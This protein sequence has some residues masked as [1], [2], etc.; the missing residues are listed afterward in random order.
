MAPRTSTRSCS[1]VRKPSQFTINSFLILR[2]A[3][4][5][6]SLPLFASKLSTCHKCYTKCT[7]HLNSI[8]QWTTHLLGFS[9]H[10]I[11]KYY[12]R[13]YFASQRENSLHIFLWF[14]KLLKENKINCIRVN[15]ASD[16]RCENWTLTVVFVEQYLWGN[17]WHWYIDKVCT[18]LSSYRFCKHCFTCSRRSKEQYSLHRLPER[19]VLVAL[20]NVTNN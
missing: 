11:D 16:K 12:C 14:S 13:R 6:L 17:D 5:S 3:S 10:L 1:L 7:T 18:W 8:K 19:N 4:C 2:I 9:S 15:R 20:P